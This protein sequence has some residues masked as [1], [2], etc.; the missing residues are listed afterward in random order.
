VF[1]IDT[2]ETASNF[3]LN[4]AALKKIALRGRRLQPISGV[5]TRPALKT[6]AEQTLP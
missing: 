1:S 4:L 2:L 5:I 3:I 6:I